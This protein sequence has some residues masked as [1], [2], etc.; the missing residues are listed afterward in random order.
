M[1]ATEGTYITK[2]E[3]PL[4]LSL[5]PL[6]P[7]V[8]ILCRVFVLWMDWREEMAIRRK[9]LR[10][11]QKEREDSKNFI[12]YFLCDLC[13]AWLCGLCVEGLRDPPP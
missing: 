13:A 10:L 6:L 11:L 9:G 1:E 12:S 3:A 4:F 8:K 2:N 7:P 5:F